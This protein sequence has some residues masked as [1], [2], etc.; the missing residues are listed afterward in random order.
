MMYKVVIADDEPIM[1]KA[2]QTLIDWK[3]IECQLVSVVS[4]GQEVM[5]Y[6]QNDTPDI[7]I[8]DIKM[9]GM[10]GI[11]LARYVYEEKLSVKIILLTAYTDFSYAQNAVKYNVVD[12]VIKTGSFEELQVAIEKAKSEIQKSE[13]KMTDDQQVLLKENFFKSVFDGSLYFQEDIMKRAERIGIISKKAWRVIMIRFRLLDKKQRPYLYQSIL[14]F[15]SMVFEQQM[16]CGMPMKK[17]EMVVVLSDEKGNLEDSVDAQCMQIVELMEKFMKMKVYIGISR[18]CAKLDD[19][20]SIFDEAQYAVEE[21]CFYENGKIKHY[22]QM[23]KERQES[24]EAIDAYLKDLYFYMKKGMQEESFDIFYKILECFKNNEYSMNTIFDIGIEIK[25]LCKK[26][27]S[28]YDKILYDFVP[29]ERNISQIIYKCKYVS[30]YVEIMIN[31]I[32][33]T[34]KYINVA[35]SKK[36]ILIY[37]AEKYIDENYQ[38]SITVSEVARKVGVSLSYLSR[39]YK[40]VTGNT[41]INR[42]NL[43]KIEKAKD[44]LDNTSMKIYEIAEILGF[45]NT[46]YFSYFFKKNTGMSPKEYKERK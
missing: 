4:S 6:L 23:E 14:R 10:N 22:I 36:N 5:E 40:E 15:L 42:I 18:C 26:L 28:E 43:K 32:G 41:L 2:M 12:Y 33:S 35:V 27:L 11:D 30:E 9:P 24:L 45:E 21:S 25:S 39:I 8:L 44:Y 13:L 1:R 34:V 16:I 31:I 17:E 3:S 19:L 20:K 37:E 46:T 38:K 29:Y 7:L